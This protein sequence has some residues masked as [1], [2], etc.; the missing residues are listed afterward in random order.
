MV[1]LSRACL[2]LIL[3]FSLTTSTAY[4]TARNS[5]QKVIAA[6]PEAHAEFGWASEVLGNV[7]AFSVD[8][9]QPQPGTVVVFRKDGSQDTASQWSQEATLQGTA[10]RTDSFGHSLALFEARGTLRMAASAW[11]VN[12]VHVFVC[13]SP[14]SSSTFGS[15][16]LSAT[17]TSQDSAS[18]D[19]FGRYVAFGANL[20]AVGAYKHDGGMGAV[21]V[22]HRSSGSET[23]YLEAKLQPADV[24]ANDNFGVAVALKDEAVLV[25]AYCGV[26]KSCPG[27]AYVFRRSAAQATPGGAWSQEARLV[28]SGGEGQTGDAYGHGVALETDLAVVGAPWVDSKTGVVFVYTRAT[29]TGQWGSERALIPTSAQPGS[30]FGRIPQVEGQTI[31]A[32][33]DVQGLLN[34]PGYVHVWRLVNDAWVETYTLVAVDGA[35]GD[36]GGH[37]V[38]LSGNTVVSAA[39]HAF[40][41]GLAQAGAGYI[42]NLPSV[43]AAPTTSRIESPT[44]S[45][46]TSRNESPTRSPT[47]GRIESPTQNP[48]TAP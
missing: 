33:S 25:G 42:F 26:E 21:Y 32:G 27:A 6:T 16:T 23:W 47:V 11:A 3:V 31:V 1:V 30:L 15:W 28:Q 39:Y 44:Q 18:G 34:T 19:F 8:R 37:H 13:S 24:Q 7:A 4:I 35:S 36:A 10:P 12:Q 43:Q 48:T 29:E 38:S 40:V 9:S 14:S 2:H 41:D 20:V 5:D 22:F 45:P 46:T 17:L